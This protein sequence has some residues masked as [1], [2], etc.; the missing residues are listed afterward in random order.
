MILKY[1][2]GS[3]SK[4]KLSRAIIKVFG[5]GSTVEEVAYF[6]EDKEIAYI[7]KM[8][9]YGV[10]IVYSYVYNHNDKSYVDTVF[11]GLY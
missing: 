8:S 4:N 1:K 3:G 5:D 10:I 11:Y 7:A 2:D 6:D 9:Q